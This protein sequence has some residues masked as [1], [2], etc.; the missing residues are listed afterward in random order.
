LIALA[1]A[2]PYLR[3]V[4]DTDSDILTPENESLPNGSVGHKP[5]SSPDYRL[6]QPAPLNGATATLLDVTETTVTFEIVKT[7]DAPLY[8][9]L[10]GRR[11]DV[12]ASSEP[13]YKDN[14][15]LIRHGTLK[16][17]VNG[18][19]SP[20]YELPTAAGSYRVTVDFTSIRNGTY[21][22]R[23][24]VGL[25]AYIGKDGEPVTERFSLEVTSKETEAG[26]ETSPETVSDIAVETSPATAPETTESPETTE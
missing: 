15:V 6:D 23:E 4:I 11:G 10:Y 12:L 17:Y 19:E 2:F 3:E 16:L 8:F 21:P 7:D 26:T 9:I 5:E 18:D 13:D 20:V 14:G 22:M 24:Y 25:Y 1:V